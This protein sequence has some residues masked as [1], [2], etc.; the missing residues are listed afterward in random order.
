MYNFIALIQ[1]MQKACQ[2]NSKLLEAEKKIQI[3]VI[4]FAQFCFY[5]RHGIFFTNGVGIKA[6]D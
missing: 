2:A 6:H 3:V 5:T 1:I 4:K